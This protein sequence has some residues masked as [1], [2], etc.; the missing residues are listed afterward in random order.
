[1]KKILSVLAVLAVASSAFAQGL[2]SFSAPANSIQYKVNPTDAT[3]VNVPSSGGFVSLLWAPAGSAATTWDGSQSLAQ[4]LGAN[5]AWKQY[6]ATAGTPWSKA[7]TSQGRLLNTGVTLT[8]TAA[9]DL[10]LIGWFGTATSFD[11]AYTAGAQTDFSDK[12]ANITPAVSPAPPTSVSFASGLTMTTVVPE[13]S[14]F[15]LAGLG[16]A[17]L[18]IFRRRK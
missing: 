11:A 8:T 9:V 17:A 7:I 2:I 5:S 18:L 16:A 3:A 13:P 4:W 14:T 6:E 1:M 12:I 10:I 15:A